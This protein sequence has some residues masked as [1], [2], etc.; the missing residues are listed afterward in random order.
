[1]GLRTG[2]DLM[3]NDYDVG[4]IG[5]GLMGSAMTRR[6]LAHGYRVKVWNRTP[7]KAEPLCAAGAT[8]SPIERMNCRRLIISLY[9]SAAVGEVID[10]NLQHFRVGQC[11]IDTT[12]GSPE[13]S[14]RIESLLLDRGVYYFDA[15][16]SGSSEQTQKGDAIFIVGGDKE[17]YDSC[18]DLWSLLGRRSFHVGPCGSAS[19]IKLISN[20]VLGLNRAALAESLAYAEAIGIDPAAAL[21]V[22]K[23]SS[24]YSK[25]MDTK[26]RKM[27]EEDFSLQA[28]LS[29]HLKDVNLMLESAQQAGM[30][31]PMSNCHRRLLEKAI[32]EGLGDLDN[33]AIY[34]VFRKPVQT[35]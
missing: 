4:V 17:A 19:K 9:D 16:I 23:H 14:A 2:E 5:L 22:L 35:S 27:V 11:L 15:P 6:L 29:Q 25:V 1:M 7:S 26:G 13:E 21:D 32:Q 24:A 10:R 31:L 28:R 34:Q 20:L 12:T 18:Q 30:S 8:W 33:S 3:S